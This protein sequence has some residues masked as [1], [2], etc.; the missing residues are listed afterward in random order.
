MAAFALVAVLAVYARPAAAANATIAMSGPGGA[1]RF[2]PNIATVNVGDTVT[3]TNTGGGAHTATAI[4]SAFN[5][6]LNATATSGTWVPTAAGTYYFYC[7]VH[8]A[9]TEATE[10]RVQAN[11]VQVGKIVVQAAAPA[12]V[13]PPV[14]PPVVPPVGTVGVFTGST[15]A[16]QGVTIVSFTGTV[17]QLGTAGTAAKVVSASATTG[18]KMTTYVVGAPDFVNAEFNAVFPAGLSATFL[19]LKT[20]T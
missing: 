17:A 20:G 4:N 5:V 16:A 15:I 8:S 9:P 14:V 18:G 1:G 13:T 7:A 12:P 2:I 3:F 6:P 19:I 10:A 11:D